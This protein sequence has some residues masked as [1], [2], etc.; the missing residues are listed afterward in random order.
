LGRFHEAFGSDKYLGW[1]GHSE[2]EIGFQSG[3]CVLFRASLLNHLNGFDERFFYH[4][5]EA[6]LCY[7]VWKDGWSIVFCPDAE[8]TH[9]GG[10]SV[11]RFPVRFALETY[12]SRY[13]FFFKH[14]GVKGL[15]RVRRVSILGL[16][17]RCFGYS[18]INGVKPSEVITNRLKCDRAVLAWNWRLDPMRFID[19]GTE[20]ET[21]YAPLA[22]APL[23]TEWGG[24]W[25][26]RRSS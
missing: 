17:L 23:M 9:L 26:E 1:D 7:R 15:R 8:I 12:R 22:P 18:L 10:Q 5:E 16:A 20:P 3:C 11:G 21:E 13:R 24:V 14:F 2:R 4:F 19:D 25:N 6:D